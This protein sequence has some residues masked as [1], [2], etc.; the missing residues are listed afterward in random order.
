M[1][2]GDDK[3]KWK[4]RRLLTVLSVVIG[5]LLIYAAAGFWILPAVLKSKIPDLI[6]DRLPVKTSI[7][8]IKLNPFLLTATVRDL[9]VKAEDGEHLVGLKALFANL[10]LSSLFRWTV[11]L[12]EVRLTEPDTTIRILPDGRIN[13]MVPL[14]ALNKSEGAEKE[15]PIRLPIVEVERF[16]LDGGKIVF[17]DGS[18]QI[19]FEASLNPIRVS[20]NGFT[21]RPDTAFD[22]GFSAATDRSEQFSGQGQATL[23]PL[24]AKGALSATGVDIRRLWQA[25]RDMVNFEITGG[26]IDIA[27]S[28][29]TGVDKNDLR[30][31]LTDGRL[32]L[33]GFLLADRDSSVPLVSVPALSVAGVGF[34]LAQRVFR[35]AS[36]QSED[37]RIRT[38]I[39]PD[40]S[41]QLLEALLPRSES[42]DPIQAAPPPG[43]APAFDVNEWKLRIDGI[44]VKNAGIELQDRGLTPPVPLNYGP[45]NLSVNNLSNR[46][47]AAASV[48]LDVRDDFGGRFDTSGQISVNPVGVDLKVV[49]S[50]AAIEKV[51]PYI[52]AIVDVDVVSGVVDLDG[53]VKY[54]GG[55]SGPKLHYQG[56]MRVNDVKITTPGDQQ[57]LAGFRSL[58][59]N[60]EQIDFEPNRYEIEEIVL[61]GLTGNLVIETDGRLRVN[62]LVANL[63]KEDADIAGTLP[64]RVVRAIKENIRGPVPLHIDKVLV[65]KSSV[66]FEDRSVKPAFALALEEVEGRMTGISSVGDDRVQVDIGGRIDASTPLKISG[67]LVPFGEKTDMEMRVS[68][69]NFRLQNISSY[70]GKHVGYTIQ[71]GQLSLALEYTLR[72]DIIDG[73]NEILLQQLTLG[74]RTDSPD[75]ISLPLDLA[76]AL[77]KDSDGNIRIKVPVR[78]DIN[79]PDFSV[80]NVLTDTLIKFVTGIVSSP[81]KIVEGL[82]GAF[83]AADLERI[84]FAPGSSALK[85]DQVKKLV[86]VAKSLRERPSLQVEISGI[87]Y[88]DIDGDVLNA[89]EARAAPA[90]DPGFD[91]EQLQELARQRADSIRRALIFAG[92]IESER[93][94]ILPEKVEKDSKPKKAASRLSLTVQ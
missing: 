14:E 74:Q 27:G 43:T 70:S 19:P 35:V 81:F 33:K 18:A 64:A 42:S 11:F 89:E 75:A 80:G 28:F 91:Q 52:K 58:A 93:V 72:A 32:D 46:Q 86:A 3:S 24:A 57:L 6:A 2:A 13:L 50:N 34:D 92:E 47:G 41:V 37:A 29:S 90:E 49:V 85:D 55:G 36:V 10:Q 68:L 5:L 79:N 54:A 16:A 8:Q 51:E 30:M 87:A 71:E 67:S 9:T 12:K 83:T 88:V 20:V 78:G 60:G 1:P 59:I 38:W 4:K 77:L 21:T 76:V 17:R 15:E 61:D 39:S 62:Q 69:K 65:E 82:A 22:F 94:R 40:G 44:A 63:E 84:Y 31:Q 73:K 7:G 26:H 23:M 56:D 48:E 45:I 25:F 66:V 53:Q